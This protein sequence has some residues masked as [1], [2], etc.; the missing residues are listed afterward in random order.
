M[1]MEDGCCLLLALPPARDHT[2]LLHALR[3]GVHDDPSRRCFTKLQRPEPS[4]LLL[5]TLQFLH[6]SN[7]VFPLWIRCTDPDGFSDDLD[8]LVSWLTRCFFD[9]H[10]TRKS[11]HGQW[12]LFLY[13]R[14][15]P[16]VTCTYYQHDY[17]QV[18]MSSAAVGVCI[19]VPRLSVGHRAS[20]LR[21][22]TT[23]HRPVSLMRVDF[24]SELKIY[25]RKFQDFFLC[26]G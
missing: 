10:A 3:I 24:P 20:L 23:R 22:T 13:Q 9:R 5:I 2:P 1:E 26:L 12:A 16:H 21:V 15:G 11:V 18:D 7:W 25:A 17:D 6:V 4:L 8:C 14:P 19:L